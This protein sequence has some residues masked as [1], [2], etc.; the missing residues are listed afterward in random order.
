MEAG[1]ELDK[2]EPKTK[3][4][5][6]K[7][8]ALRMAEAFAVI[9]IILLVLF[10][11]ILGVAR[12]SGV[13]MENTFHDGE[14]VL[15]Y[16]LVSEYQRGDVVC[17]K[18]TNGDNYIKRIIGVPGDTLELQD[19]QVVLNGYALTESYAV[20]QTWPETGSVTYPVELG[21]GEYFVIGDN[22][23]ESVDSRSF[24]PVTKAQIKG[25]ILN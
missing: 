23:E 8:S 6:A 24:G 17:I 7:L 11:K 3:Y 4:S 22:R 9:V 1:E 16:R 20:G 12:V 10:L 5:P 25:K 19:G 18:M 21:E 15:Y 14:P 2:N 13:S